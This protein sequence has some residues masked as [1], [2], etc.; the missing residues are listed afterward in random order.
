MKLFFPPMHN[1]VEY[2]FAKALQSFGVKMLL[3]D[4]SFEGHIHYGRKWTSEA[5]KNEMPDNVSSISYYDLITNKDDD[6]VILISCFEVQSDVIKN[7]WNVMGG[8]NKKIVHYSGNDNTFHHYDKRYVK[9]MLAADIGSYAAAY[10]SD[11]HVLNYYPWVNYE[12]FSYDGPSDSKVVRSFIHNYKNLFSEDFKLAEELMSRNCE[13]ADWELIDGKS[14]DE[15]VP[16]MKDM[17]ANLHIKHIEGYGFAILESLACGRP[18]LLYKPFAK[19]RSY[20]KWC[21]EDKSALYFES[22]EEFKSKLTKLVTDEE[23]RHSLQESTANTVRKVVNNEE[24]NN[25]LKLFFENLK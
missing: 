23:Y 9:N 6:I 5:V 17:M 25:N 24:Q 4:H 13:L 2:S 8:R 16:L 12:K 1:T 20:T 10:V 19:D 15:T 14:K 18:C 22:P 7:I 3:P 21:I 11:Y